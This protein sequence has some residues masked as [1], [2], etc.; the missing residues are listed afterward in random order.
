MLPER[1]ER[2]TVIR[3]L[4]YLLAQGVLKIGSIDGMDEHFTPLEQILEDHLKEDHLRFKN[5]L[6]YL[7]RL[8]H[9]S[10]PIQVT[11]EICAVGSCQGI[12]QT[13]KELES[14]PNRTSETTQT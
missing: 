14:P 4:D 3:I 11:F 10:H 12:N 8:N 5:W 9:R 6:D 1:P 2:A 7:G 13:I